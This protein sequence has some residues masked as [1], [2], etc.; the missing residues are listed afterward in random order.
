MQVVAGGGTSTLTVNRGIDST[1]PAAHTSGTSISEVFA[2]SPN[3]TT[4]T[5]DIT[6]T[7][8]T[9]PVASGATIANGEFLVIDGEYM[10]VTAGGGTTSLTVTRGLLGTTAAAH[11]TAAQVSSSTAPTVAPGTS[12]NY[13]MTLN[14]TDVPGANNETL[15]NQTI[16][17]PPSFTNVSLPV[18]TTL[19]APITSATQTS[20]TVTSATG[21]VT[22]A[23]I[24][25]DGEYMTVTA[26]GGTTS[27]TVTRGQS[28]NDGQNNTIA[29]THASGAQVQQASFTAF[30]SAG[31]V[32]GT[33]LESI[34]GNFIH[35]YENK[36]Q[37]LQPGDYVTFQFAAT[38]ASSGTVVTDS[39]AWHTLVTRDSTQ[40]FPLYGAQPFVVV[41]PAV[42]TADLQIT[43]TDNKTTAVP[44]T[45]N[46]Y[47]IV[48]TNA[49]PSSVTGAT[50]M[51]T[52]PASLFN[53]TYTASATGG[54]TGFTASGSGNI[55]DTVTMP[56]GSTITYLV[57]GTISPNATGSLSNT[58][59]VTPPAGVTD[60]NTGNNSATD[61]DTLTPQNDVSVTKTDGVTTVVPGQST[62]YTIT[63]HNGGPSTATNVI[64]SD[65]LPA[66]VTSFVWSGNGHTNVSGPLS[67]TIA[68]LLPGGSVTYT[69]TAQIDASATGSVR[70]TVT[71]TAAND[72][73]SANNSATDPDALIPQADLGVVK[74]VD[75]PTPNVG[76]TVTFTVTVNNS[77]P[78]TATGVAV[79]DDLPAGLTFLSDTPTQG[80][81]SSITGVWNVG[82]LNNGASA[83]LLL[84]A[85]V[86]SPDALTNTASIADSSAQDPNPAND[87]ASATET[88]RRVDL[89]VSKTDGG[90]SVNAGG[91]V[92]YTIN[93]SNGGTGNA[94]GVFLNEFL[95]QGTT[96]ND[97]ASTP[98]WIA[99]GSDEFE[100]AVGNL[101]AGA[102]G[103]VAFAVTVPS[104]VPAGLE[105]I[106]NTVKIAD[107][108]THG[109]DV[110][111]ANNTGTDSTPVNAAPDLVITKTD[112]GTTTLP[113]GIVLYQITYSNVGTQDATGVVIT[114]TLPSNTTFNS[115][116]SF[117][118]WQTTDGLHYTLII[119]DVP[120]GAS[121]TVTFAVTV[122]SNLPGDTTEI[123]NRVAIADDGSNGA[124]LN[125][126]DNTAT[127]TTPLQNNPKNDL[128]ITKT[129]GVTTVE[130]GSIVTYIVVITN[131]GPTAANGALFT[132][133]VPDSLTG[134]TYTT[135]IVSTSVSTPLGPPASVSPASGSG[136]TITGIL[137]VPKG[138]TITYIITGTL[139]PNATGTLTNIATVLPPAGTL[140]TNTGNNTA[141]DQDQIVGASDLSLTKTFTYT[142][143]DGSGT[144]T[145]GDEIVFTITATNSGPDPAG[146]VSVIDL[147]PTGYTYVSDD[148]ALDGGSYAPGTGLWTIGT[149]GAAAPNN[150]AVLHVTAI[151]NPSGTYTNSADV[152]TSD[153]PDPDSTPGNNVPTEDD[154]ASVT[155][156]VQPKSDLS[157]SKTMA[158]TTDADGNGQLSIGDRVTFTL[159]LNNVGPDP[160]ANVHVADLLPAGYSFFSANASQGTYQSA[161]GDWN[162]G[163][164]DVLSSPMLTIVATVVGGK[165]ASAYTNYAEVSASGSFDPNSTP[166]DHSTDQDDDASVTPQI[167]DLSLTKTAS[168]ASD[169]DDSG[170]YTVGDR[171]AFT[172]NVTNSGPDFATGV[173]VKDL[174]ASGFTYVS[175]DGL[176]TYNP[177]TGLW[178]VGVLAPGETAT[179]IILA[180]TNASGS[181]VNTAQVVASQQFDPDSTPN[182]NVPSEDDQATITLNPGAASQ[183]PV[184]VN[185]SSLRNPPGPVT[186][187]ETNKDSDPNF[188]LLVSTVDLDPTTAGIQTTKTVAGQ[189]TWT[190][191]S[192]GNVTFTPQLG[193]THD[194][195]PITY[196]VQDATGKTSNQATITIDYLPVATDD[197]STGNTTGTAVTVDVL[198]NDTTGDT[199]IPTTVQIVGTPGAG[200]SLT[201]PDEGTWSVNTTT[202][203]ITFTPE[204]GFT[205]DPTP[206]QYTVRGAQWQ[207]PETEAIVVTV[208]YNQ[209]PPVAFDDSS[210]HNPPGPVTLN[211]TANDTDPNNDLKPS[212]VDLDPGTP[213][214][215]RLRIVAGQGIWQVDTAGN[216]TFSPEVG[217]THDPTPITYTVQGNTGLT[218][219]TATIT[220]DY[221]P[222]ATNDSS[223]GNT[224][225]TN[226]TVPV[227]ANDTTGDTTVPTTVRIV[228][229]PPGSTLSPDG[230][231]LTVPGQGTWTVNA[232]TGAITF[233]PVP[234]FI[235]NPTPIQYAVQDAQGNTSNPAIVTV[236]YVF[237]D[238]SIVKTSNVGSVVP[239]QDN[240]VVYTIVVSNA[241]PSTAT[242]V[243]VNDT[244]P[245]AVT[246][247][248]WTTVISAGSSSANP[249]GSGNIAD[250]VTLLPGGSV[251]YFV[252]ATVHPDPSATGTIDNTATVTWTAAQ[253]DT[254]PANNTSTA[255][256]ALAPRNDVSVTKDDGVTTVV[257]AARRRP[258]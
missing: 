19:A 50:V 84:R 236:G 59:T 195:T 222:V 89:A 211:V 51:D 186:H 26:G 178:N 30:T 149:I 192:L 169:V 11:A 241:G 88:P 143:L 34:D 136:N 198:A 129:D 119:G 181:Y 27:L 134:V 168:L 99:L 63:V 215:Q 41:Q 94:T 205:G 6:A 218:S 183:P 12:Q 25:I 8:T 97:A 75:N 162:V 76:D 17:L 179:L 37:P 54:A 61:T 16:D 44:G 48:V 107:D 57:T 253:G 249:T 65:P 217:F 95:P 101:A 33:W 93:Y 71:A 185:D 230:K 202:G 86:D 139:D 39:A 2:L 229:P 35:L 237:S 1:Y 216:V 120:V 147:L 171:V 74:T 135:T 132:D 15:F 83:S 252:T 111:P 82:T 243:P 170:T 121:G 91:T 226:V 164:V 174:L 14:N 151:V 140:D 13:T 204:P 203:A 150:T 228:N 68:S 227:L 199:T 246:S 159:T 142:D 38:A 96:F 130:P 47:T 98:G 79:Q 256:L 190:V 49:G 201:V 115:A 43:K 109:A 42:T 108:G 10:Q 92:T 235:G 206:I 21:I 157:L 153:N 145:P 245:S 160:A 66:G 254:T 67:D 36:N 155:P 224:L 250:I 165:P 122:D 194:P 221:A 124:D 128:Q 5:G 104:P 29:T 60:P 251:I 146:N 123:F 77:G 138:A 80:T 154:H 20:I 152:F 24:A 7:Q 112:G 148:A 173:Q 189:G 180:A 70:N 55:N 240:T 18:L 167:A 187:N 232:T 225:G 125:P 257:P 56:V 247:A 193:F 137:N 191:D 114:E 46:T 233:S 102:S 127:D 58:A 238:V 161:T 177:A 166:G 31:V 258:T 223:L 81:Y 141:I 69:V 239:G 197:F 113:G 163:T 85:R 182:N 118:A 242:G 22:G 212:T 23:T 219:N 196:T 106:D 248:S 53:E 184:A 52:F 62:T 78:S 207:L 210:L 131:L 32:R 172:V 110:N 3:V 255:S 64:V 126:A 100:F 4:L 176:G 213:G 209:F 188:D 9:I 244:F 28:Y 208:D 200:S 234:G 87:T 40:V 158:L 105:Q 220:I 90:V 73:N 231:T 116:S 72:T 117:G 214:Q 45:S 175:D 133:N 103:S 144:L 156:V